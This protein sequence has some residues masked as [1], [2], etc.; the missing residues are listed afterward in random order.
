MTI[1]L[2][3]NQDITPSTMAEYS[4]IIRDTLRQ[5]IE[6]D[7]QITFILQM[8][9]TEAGETMQLVLSSQVELELEELA[10][11]ENVLMEGIFDLVEY[12]IG[13]LKP[14]GVF[15]YYSLQQFQNALQNAEDLATDRVALDVET[16]EHVWGSAIDAGV[17]TQI[18]IEASREGGVKLSV[19]VGHLIQADTSEEDR[20]E[21]EKMGIPHS[22]KSNEFKIVPLVSFSTESLK[23]LFTGKSGK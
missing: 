6:D 19:D 11:F 10:S 8:N 13:Q 21:L 14:L 20:A 2:A 3:E 22:G 17:A 16:R 12:L 18:T 5:A 23:N 1:E 4:P 15:S 9:H 7:E